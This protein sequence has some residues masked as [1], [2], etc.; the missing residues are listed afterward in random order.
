[1]RRPINFGD[2]TEGRVHNLSGH[3]RGLKAR[4]SFKLDQL[5]LD[6]IR[7]VIHVPEDIYGISPSFVQGLFS[8]TLKKLGNDIDEFRR[9]YE[10]DAT[11]LVR[12][13]IERGLHNIVLDRSSPLC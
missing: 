13:Q 7:H 4:E 12:R 11:D 2:L 8:A 5:D 9:H 6:G 3:E 10:I 1:M